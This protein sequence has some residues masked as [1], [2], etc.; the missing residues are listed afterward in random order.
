[1][2]KPESEL[3]NRCFSDTVGEAT[4]AERRKAA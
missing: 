1:M 2:S 4:N 3:P